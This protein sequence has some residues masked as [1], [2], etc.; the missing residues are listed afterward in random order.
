MVDGIRESNK[1]WA[2]N[3]FLL[4][5]V[6]KQLTKQAER[7][8]LL[9]K[10]NRDLQDRVTKL[11]ATQS[12]PVTL[13]TPMAIKETFNREDA[14]QLKAELTENMADM[15]KKFEEMITGK[16]TYTGKKPAV[17]MRRP[18]NTRAPVFSPP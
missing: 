4:E 9:T 10:E 14:D 8:D 1:Q 6:V 15:I 7:M 17:P 5:E 12:A 2:Q 11:E 18:T 16:L 3:H 13:P